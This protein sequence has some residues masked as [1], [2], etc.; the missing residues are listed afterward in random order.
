MFLILFVTTIF[1]VNLASANDAF[2]AIGIGGI[3]I[4]KTDKIAMI[5]EKLFLST[6]LVEVE[7]EFENITDKNESAIISFPLPPSIICSLDAVEEG[8]C[9]SVA[10]GIEFNTWIDGKKLPPARAEAKLV[11][12]NSDK[13]YSE[14]LKKYNLSPNA[15]LKDEEKVL[16]L[17]ALSQLELENEG[18]IGWQYWCDEILWSAKKLPDGSDQYEFKGKD[19]TNALKEM[20]YGL[21]GNGCGHV[22]AL[23]LAN[24]KRI[25]QNGWIVAKKRNVRLLWLFQK[26]YNWDQ[27]FEKRKIVHVKH[28]Y[29]PRVGGAQGLDY[30]IDNGGSEVDRFCIDQGTKVGIKKQTTTLQKAGKATGG[31]TYLDYILTSANSW[32]GPIRSFELTIKKN[33]PTEIIST[34]F[35]GLKKEDPLTFKAKLENFSPKKEISILFY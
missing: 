7:Y 1:H 10:D 30:A 4:S 3:V 14:L 20:K 6:N 25:V 24:Q 34:C 5:K 29:K 22:N 12:P 27:E 32:A 31:Y 26:I 33:N 19:I 11:I 15:D 35:D 2:S 18:L 28:T 23:S 16:K 8:V 21:N 13:D 17:P 9:N